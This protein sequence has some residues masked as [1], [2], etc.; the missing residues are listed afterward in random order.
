MPDWSSPA[1]LRKD[2]DAFAKLM[3]SILGIYL[4]EWLISLDFEWDFI[5][6]KKT[7]RWP[8]IFYFL[9]RYLFLVAMILMAVSLDSIKVLNCHALYIFEQLAG[10]ACIGLASIS[11]SI[12]TMAIWGWNKYLVGSFI[13][14]ILGHWSLIFQGAQLKVTWIPG[15]GCFPVETHNRIFV[16]I[17]IYAMCFDLLILSLTTYKLVNRLS[18]NDAMGKSKLAHVIFRDG[19]IYFVIAFVANVL[20]TIFM[21]LNLNSII[22]IIFNVPAALGCT[23]SA[24]RAVRRLTNFS[25]NAPE[26]YSAS[27]SG[28]VRFK[29]PVASGS[30]MRHRPG[31]APQTGVHVQMETFTRAEEVVDPE[32]FASEAQKHRDGSDTDIE[33]DMEKGKEL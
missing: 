33:V 27:N 22:S 8:M 21:A 6:G 24:C 25:Q 26:V 15:S 2:A 30:R 29:A 31:T 4:Y 5:R 14:I 12:R 1:E 13:V 10:N 32:Y 20:A 16:V 18:G 3:H 19:L 17:F 7:F 9:N 23:I 28:Q 11:L